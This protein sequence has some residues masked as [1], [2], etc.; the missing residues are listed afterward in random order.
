MNDP[1][2]P[3]NPSGSSIPLPYTDI[4]FWAM[5][6]DYLP[7]IESYW[8][9]VRQYSREFSKHPYDD[10]IAFIRWMNYMIFTVQ[11]FKKGKKK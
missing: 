7:D 8:I 10:P 11:P 2:D 6:Y 9:L 5:Y 3:P 1:S 4:H